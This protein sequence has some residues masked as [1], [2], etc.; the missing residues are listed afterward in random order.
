MTVSLQE[1]K[2]LKPCWGGETYH[3]EVQYYMLDYFCIGD[4]RWIR[5]PFMTLQEVS[6]Y[7]LMND[8]NGRG[9]RLRVQSEE[10][11]SQPR[12]KFNDELQVYVPTVITNRQFLFGDAYERSAARTTGVPSQSQLPNESFDDWFKRIQSNW[13]EITNTPIDYKNGEW[14]ELS[15]E[16]KK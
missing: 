12:A 8:L 5:N 15:K 13:S 16:E 6:N 7:I 10:L 1:E 3:P 2:V 11:L 9:K 4:F 14:F